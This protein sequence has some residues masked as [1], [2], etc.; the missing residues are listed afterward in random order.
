MMPVGTCLGR[1]N[2]IEQDL[3]RL[4]ANDSKAWTAGRLDDGLS[5]A[6][7]DEGGANVV[8][9]EAGVVAGLAAIPA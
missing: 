2:E 3:R 9:R 8:V 4:V 6:R 1:S 7:G 5:G